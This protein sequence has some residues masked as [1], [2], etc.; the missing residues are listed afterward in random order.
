MCQLGHETQVEGLGGWVVEDGEGGDVFGS[1][2]GW[3]L[4]CRWEGEDKAGDHEGEENKVWNEHFVCVVLLLLCCLFVFG[5]L[6]V[7]E[8]IGCGSL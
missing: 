6:S 1:V 2:P 8:D 4:F 3:F 7:R 5:E